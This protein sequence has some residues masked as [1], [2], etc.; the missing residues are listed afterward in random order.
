MG[1]CRFCGTS[2]GLFRSEHKHC[3]QEDDLNR[4]READAR[5]EAAKADAEARTR[6]RDEAERKKAEL[7]DW[8]VAAIQREVNLAEVEL[9]L[10]D[11]IDLHKLDIG[12]LR[13]TLVTAFDRLVEA[14][15]EDGVIDEAEES[16]IVEFKDRFF[17][18]EADLNLQGSYM[19]V[20]RSAVLRKVMQGDMP[21]VEVDPAF[22][23]N[24]QKGEQPAFILQPCRYLEEV[25]KRQ[26]VGGSQGVSVRV[27]SGVYYRVG[28]FKGSPVITKETHEVGVGALVPTNKHLYWVNAHKS[29]RIPYRKIISINP[30]SDGIGIVK[31][32]VTAKPQYFITE[33]G[34]FTYNLVK[35]LAANA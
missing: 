23:I 16:R 22:P 31:E 12:L 13:P 5:R 1:T 9:H 2:A 10:R 4:Q 11:E 20:I 18:S 7:L 19:R 28:A 26:F 33:D 14:Y 17:F 35:N 8:T 6:A 30:F 24:F 29:V 21:A 3:K 34:W 27:M 15:L 25:T 32:G